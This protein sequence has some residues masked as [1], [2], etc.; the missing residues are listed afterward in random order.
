MKL[1]YLSLFISFITL[2][3]SCRS[4]SERKGTSEL[5]FHPTTPTDQNLKNIDSMTSRL[6]VLEGHLRAKPTDIRWPPLPRVWT[7]IGNSG[8]ETEI[9]NLG[10]FGVIPGMNI[11][12]KAQFQI[13]VKHTLSS[14]LKIITTQ[15]GDKPIVT[16]KKD[17]RGITRE[18]FNSDEISP[19][20]GLCS[21]TARVYTSTNKMSELSFFGNGKGLESTDADVV[22]RTTYSPFFYVKRDIPIEAYVNQICRSYFDSHIKK[23][24][25]EDLNA[26]AAGSLSWKLQTNKCSPDWSYV[27][28]KGKIDLS[29]GDPTCLDYKQKYSAPKYAIP[30]CEPTKSADPNSPFECNFYSNENG[31][32]PLFLDK[33]NK[34]HQRPG[35]GR[36]RVTGTA[37]LNGGRF[38][39]EKRTQI[40]PSLIKE[41]TSFYC[42]KGFECRLTEAPITVLGLPII[43]GKSVCVKKTTPP[44][45]FKPLPRFPAG[46]TEDLDSKGLLNKEPTTSSAV[47]E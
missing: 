23:A 29:L 26:I 3:S 20:V 40:H 32:C 24:T 36:T 2:L 21:Y 43:Y 33:E 34:F 28:E 27:K 19:F 47:Y 15:K 31:A 9:T 11:S 39:E 46:S 25:I 44:P 18:Y 37:G 1:I 8:S 12:A 30:R 4:F 6:P 16:Y 14:F 22:S 17:A 10:F 13:E 42:D 38:I 45:S 7:D 35:P 41:Q 5:Q